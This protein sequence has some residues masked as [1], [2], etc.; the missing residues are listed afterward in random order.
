MTCSQ[1]SLTFYKPCWCGVVGGWWEQF[2]HPL[3]VF[4]D[5]LS[6]ATSFRPI[7][8]IMLESDMAAKKN[9]YSGPELKVRD[10]FFERLERQFRT[11]IDCEHNSDDH[12]RLVLLKPVIE[13]LL[14]PFVNHHTC[15]DYP[16]FAKWWNAGFTGKSTSN[17][18]EDHSEIAKVAGKLLDEFLKR[19]R[20]RM[21]KW[22]RPYRVFETSCFP[23]KWKVGR[24]EDD[25][26]ATCNYFR[27]RD[28]AQ[29][30]ANK[31]NKVKEN[32][33]SASEKD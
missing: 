14:A 4:N 5:D 16:E 13:E 32:V 17:R 28:D 24:F 25:D 30:E 31:R 12:L 1:A 3:F 33:R 22:D 2:H 26:N 15:W 8:S 6:S 21:S 7:P 19:I 10:G 29:Q 18:T 23:A 9:Q 20:P 11:Q 27:D